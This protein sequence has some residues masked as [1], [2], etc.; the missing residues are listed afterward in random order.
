[1]QATRSEKI[2]LRLT[3]IAKRMLY[4]AAMATHRS[5][6]EF[7]L[8]SALSRAEETLPDRQT[9]GL[10]ATQWQNFI[11]ALDAPPRDM[12]RLEKLLNE[13]SVFERPVS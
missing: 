10:N 12:P 6:S 2:D 4:Q 13:P 9:F 1:M 7:V 8:E 3:P 11:A 5:V